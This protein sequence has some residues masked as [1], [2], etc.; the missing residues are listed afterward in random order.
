MQQVY[1]IGSSRMFYDKR[2]P[3]ARLCL[4]L[5][6]LRMR[7]RA[8]KMYSAAD[9]IRA[10]LARHG[11]SLSDIKAIDFSTTA[12]NTGIDSANGFLEIN[13]ASGP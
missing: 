6:E 9:R 5:V 13:A 7:Y 1:M 11:I 2:S 10:F 12:W 4:A 8:F 3:L